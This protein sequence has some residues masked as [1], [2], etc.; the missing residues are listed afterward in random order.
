[1]AVSSEPIYARFWLRFAAWLTDV[2]IFVVVGF[3]LYTLLEFAGLLIAYAGYLVYSSVLEGSSY[4][5]TFGK[6]LV[7]LRVTDLDG[8]RLSWFRAAGRG[9]ARL[10]STAV[11][12]FGHLI[13]AFTDQKQTLHD[14]LASTLVVERQ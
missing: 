12:P 8:A 6:F 5:A 10:V 2:V 3:L 9:A 13:V 14:L 1:M 4:N 7:G 11:F